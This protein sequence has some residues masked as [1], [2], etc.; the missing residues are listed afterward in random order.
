M[1]HHGQC[2]L[3]FQKTLDMILLKNRAWI[4]RAAAALTNFCAK[5]RKLFFNLPMSCTGLKIRRSRLKYRSE[6]ENHC[7]IFLD[8]M[9][10]PM[11]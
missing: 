2:K 6:Q 3:S 10:H 1:T 7:F 4:V 5:K 8:V 9:L 11:I